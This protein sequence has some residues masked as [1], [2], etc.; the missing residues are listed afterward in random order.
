MQQLTLSVTRKKRINEKL[1]WN[2]FYIDPKNTSCANVG[3][4]SK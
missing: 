4:M 3:K 2:P 1:R